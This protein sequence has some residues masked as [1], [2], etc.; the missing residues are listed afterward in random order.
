MSTTLCGVTSASRSRTSAVGTTN[1]GMN[2]LACLHGRYSRSNRTSGKATFAGANS[3]NPSPLSILKGLPEAWRGENAA[4]DAAGPLC[5]F[6]LSFWN[7]E[8]EAAAGG[9]AEWKANG[10]KAVNWYQDYIV[11][12]QAMTPVLKHSDAEEALAAATLKYGSTMAKNYVGTRYAWS[13][14]PVI[15]IKSPTSDAAGNGLI[16]LAVKEI[17]FS[18]PSD[19]SQNV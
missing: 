6:P 9:G 10:A 2:T 1:Q 15:E 3:M 4:R 18:V 16:A 14:A 13:I 7:P 5:E 12:K 11:F 8:R 19:L 17:V